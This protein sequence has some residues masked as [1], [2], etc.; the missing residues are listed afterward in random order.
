MSHAI[1]EISKAQ[2]RKLT[3][4]IKTAADDLWALL[5]EAHEGKAWRAL[6]YATWEAYI[7]A[8]F[9]MSR[10]QSY[11]LLDQCRVVRAIEEASGVQHV[12]Q[13][14]HRTAQAIKP[15]LPEVVAEIREKVNA[16]ADP[17]QTTYEVIEAKR[18]ERAPEPAKPAP[19]PEPEQDQP[20]IEALRSELQE[21][22]DNARQLA[23]MLESYDAVTAG[24]HAAAK[25]MARLRAQL[26]T[27]EATRDQWM[28]TAG[29][30]RKEVK[31]LQR[32][33]GARQ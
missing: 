10:R 8:E 19:K 28:T 2:A 1:A 6:G 3:D 27:V 23:E 9:D 5:L 7:G 22:R 16:G 26:R 4:R 20:E 18:I 12:A 29:E 32:K 14:S 33:L 17:I 13:I 31:S 30:L 24:E 25:E 11:N 21:T 15:D